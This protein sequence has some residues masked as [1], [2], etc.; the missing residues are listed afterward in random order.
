MRRNKANF[1]HEAQEVSNYKKMLKDY[2]SQRKVDE[3]QEYQKLSEQ[4]FLREVERENN[5]KKF[6]QDYD[7]NMGERMSNHLKYV[8]QAEI[9]KQSKLDE[10]E[11]VNQRKYREKLDK[12]HMEKEEK[13]K[14]MLK[15]MHDVNRLAY[16]RQDQEKMSKRQQYQKMVEERRKEEDEYKEYQK[17]KAEEEENKRKLYREAL[18]YQKGMQ[19]YS[20]SQLGQMTQMEKKL[21]HHDLKT[22]KQ[23]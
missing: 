11:D 17:R 9:E 7:N 23:K 14:H 16:A 20:K 5:Y 19:S 6:F 10:I 2:E 15:E 1:I 8:T 3:K 13:H 21:N 12:D 22:F 18:E 4:N